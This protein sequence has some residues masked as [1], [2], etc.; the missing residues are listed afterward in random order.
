M[1]VILT[2]TILMLVSLL[3]MAQDSVKPQ[4]CYVATVAETYNLSEEDKG[5][6]TV[7]YEAY[8]KD[9]GAIRREM[10]TEKI[11]K[12][13]FKVKRKPIRKKYFTALGA[14]TNLKGKELST[15]DKETRGKCRP[16]KKKK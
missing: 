14:L 15:L 10:K 5:K 2:T 11:T 8:M 12:E 3:S 1:K 13:E 16:K 7:A 6:L 4:D 9:F